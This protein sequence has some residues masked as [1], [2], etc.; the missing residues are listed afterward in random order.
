MRRRFSPLLVT[1]VLAAGGLAA[2]ISVSRSGIAD[3]PFTVPAQRIDAPILDLAALALAVDRRCMASE[4][5]VWPLP[6]GDPRSDG[7]VET[8]LDR[9]RD[10]G[11]ALV[12]VAAAD[13][14]RAVI[15][16]GGTGNALLL[17]WTSADDG[18]RLGLCDLG[19]P[20]RPPAGVG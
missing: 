9:L 1:L 14:S 2:Q 10:R 17:V 7:L 18:L 20:T 3:I 4:T 13:G 8:T 12:R 15:A 16:E 5:L 11:H 19:A 6:S